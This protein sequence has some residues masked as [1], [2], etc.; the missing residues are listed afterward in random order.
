MEK[1]SLD[2]ACICFTGRSLERL[3]LVTGLKLMYF[4]VEICRFRLNPKVSNSESIESTV[5]STV[6]PTVKSA[7]KSTDFY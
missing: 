3:Y 1:K 7:M 5:K 2:C 4:W 6:K